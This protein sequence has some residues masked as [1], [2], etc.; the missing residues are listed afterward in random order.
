MQN[1]KKTVK[2]YIK[3]LNH[4][5]CTALIYIYILFTIQSEDEYLSCRSK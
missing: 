4:K 5:I 3:I 1:E 2:T